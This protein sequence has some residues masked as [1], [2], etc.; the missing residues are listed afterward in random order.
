ME[1]GRALL[2]SGQDNRS[3]KT[4]DGPRD[5]QNDNQEQPG[6]EEEDEKG[7]GE[8]K[9]LYNEHCNTD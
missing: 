8:K 3:G 5:L 7:D 1:I 9:L 4:T 6:E 2:T